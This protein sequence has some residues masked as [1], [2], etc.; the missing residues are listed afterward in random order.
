MN[1]TKKLFAIVAGILIFAA[2][3]KQA[4]PIQQ[5]PSVVGFWK[6]KYSNSPSDYPNAGYAFLFR[7]DGTV[8]VYDGSDTA[9]AGKAE[10]T[11]SVTG[12]SVKT[13]YVYNEAFQFSTMAIADSHWTFMEGTW[14]SGTNTSGKGKFFVYKQ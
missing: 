3:K 12:S 7:N 1:F 5:A 14:G 8:R 2:C 6:G 4:A 11:Y 10:G 9:S 13:T